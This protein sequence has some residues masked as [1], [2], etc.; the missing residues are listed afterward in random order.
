MNKNFV[1]VGLAILLGTVTMIAPLA[2]LQDDNPFSDDAY[3][4]KTSG[5]ELE[6]QTRNDYQ[7]LSPEL[8]SDTLEAPAPSEPVIGDATALAPEESEPVHSVDFEDSGMDLFPVALITVPSFLIAF[9]VFVFL[10][11]QV[12]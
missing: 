11:R 12:S 1:Y 3:L 10:R 4:I 9:G 2:L 6:N 8:P 5:S 7:T